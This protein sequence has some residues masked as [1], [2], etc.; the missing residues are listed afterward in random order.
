[1]V[2]I[3]FSGISQFFVAGAQP[4]HLAAIA[5]LSVTDDLYSTGLPGAIFNDGF[6]ASWLAERQSDA[7]P[8]P[9]GG[10]PWAA[11]MIEDEGDEQCLEN[12]ALR[13][14]TQDIDQLIG[15]TRTATPRCS[16]TGRPPS[17]PTTSRC[18]CSSSVACRTS[19]PA[20][21]GRRS[22]R[23]WTTTRTCG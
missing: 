3:S 14:Q 1:M 6:A 12:Q 5:P 2:G 7:E 18:R 21:S 13:L 11:A 10:Q 22:S 8:A 20:A 15:R 19:R 4:P 23:P 17:G 9:E 16:T